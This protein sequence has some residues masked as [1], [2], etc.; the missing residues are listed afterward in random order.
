MF[1]NQK[2]WGTTLCATPWQRVVSQHLQPFSCMWF[3]RQTTKGC[4]RNPCHITRLH[5]SP[6]RT[7]SAF[8]F[9]ANCQLNRANLNWAYEIN[10]H[11]KFCLQQTSHNYLCCTLC[12]NEVQLCAGQP[13]FNTV[14]CGCGWADIRH[15]GFFNCEHCNCEMVVHAARL[16]HIVEPTYRF[17]PL[18]NIAK[19]GVH[20]CVSLW[21]CQQLVIAGAWAFSS[22]SMLLTQKKKI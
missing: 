1:T 4:D 7:P 11:V 20:H 3:D 2:C 21:T 19:T 18:F 8:H 10:V 22:R 16:Q 13:F 14:N 9:C 6:S 15:S 17:P 12:Y 5:C